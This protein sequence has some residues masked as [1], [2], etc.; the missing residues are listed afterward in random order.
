MI[1]SLLDPA[2]QARLVAEARR[3]AMAGFF[4]GTPRTQWLM[5]YCRHD[6]DWMGSP[7]IMILTR[8]AGYHSSGWWKNPEYERCWHLSCSF[9]EGFTTKRGDALARLFFGDDVRL[10]WIEPPATPEGAALGVWH[11]R[12]FCDEGWQP[13]KPT[14]EVYSRRMP[15]GWMS[16]SERMAA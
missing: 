2:E 8:D 12:L 9:A 16:F 11:Y 14:G 15:A 3:C 5:R 10:T 7:A 1:Q 13:I 6:F 4:D